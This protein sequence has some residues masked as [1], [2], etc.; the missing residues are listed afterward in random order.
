M[1]I[2]RDRG[3]SFVDSSTSL[4]SLS[5]SSIINHISSF[6]LLSSS[7]SVKMS[8]KRFLKASADRDMDLYAEEDDFESRQYR[9]RIRQKYRGRNLRHKDIP[10]SYE[11]TD[12]MIL[13]G[14][15][16]AIGVLKVPSGRGEEVSFG[17]VRYAGGY[18][19]HEPTMRDQLG[20]DHKA[21]GARAFSTPG[22]SFGI[23]V[24]L[25]QY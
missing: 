17:D 6:P 18:Q 19:W 10:Y 1:L 25:V 11:P 20:L 4:D 16:N 9:L 23:W 8:K 13:E 14:L 21:F 15:G 24:R 7:S 2:D 3:T 5:S 12:E 22:T